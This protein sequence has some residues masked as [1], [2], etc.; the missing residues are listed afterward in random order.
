MFEENESGFAVFLSRSGRKAL[1]SAEHPLTRAE[2]SGSEIELSTTNKQLR[3]KFKVP[4]SSEAL[5]W[6]FDLYDGRI[7]SQSFPLKSSKPQSVECL[8]DQSR[9]ALN[10]RL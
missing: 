1:L 5:C 10:G 7:I 9:V 6:D 4:E 2:V 8:V 3:C